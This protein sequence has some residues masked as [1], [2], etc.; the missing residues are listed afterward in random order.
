MGCGYQ[1]RSII[2]ST[3]WKR[4]KSLKTKGTWWFRRERE[5]IF[6]RRSTI[7]QDLQQGLLGAFGAFLLIAVHILQNACS[8]HS[9]CQA[10][11]ALYMS[12]YT[13]EVSM[14]RQD[15]EKYSSILRYIIG[16]RPLM[17]LL[18]TVNFHHTP[19][20][21]SSC[22]HVAFAGAKSNTPLRAAWLNQNEP[23]NITGFQHLKNMSVSWSSCT[24]LLISSSHETTFPCAALGNQTISTHQAIGA[25]TKLVASSTTVMH[26]FVLPGLGSKRVP[27]K[28]HQAVKIRS[29]KKTHCLCKAWS[30]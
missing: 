30:T 14:H 17:K 8:M 3:S 7:V 13:V 12:C 28:R 4:W 6:N 23:C 18:S 22:K 20:I 24:L 29:E 27:I 26:L 10:Q 1:I 25:G 15:I 9:R 19:L 11:H 2:A 21:D 16:L 5:Y